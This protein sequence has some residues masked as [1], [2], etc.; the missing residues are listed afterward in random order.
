ME[1]LQLVMS[2][3]VMSMTFYF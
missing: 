1:I 3:A 2:D